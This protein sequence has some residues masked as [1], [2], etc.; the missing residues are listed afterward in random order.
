MPDDGVLVTDTEGAASAIG[1]IANVAA[2]AIACN[3]NDMECGDTGKLSDSR[4]I[5]PQCKENFLHFTW[6]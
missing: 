4:P 2:T 5:F 1:T 3:L 6:N